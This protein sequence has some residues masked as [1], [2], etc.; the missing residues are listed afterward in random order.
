MILQPWYYLTLSVTPELW[1]SQI[2]WKT[3]ELSHKSHILNLNTH[4]S[5][6]RSADKEERP[7][8][9]VKDKAIVCFSVDT[10]P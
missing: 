9:G 1:M 2:M 7:C 3:E 6:P 8:E 4:V 10:W 5:E